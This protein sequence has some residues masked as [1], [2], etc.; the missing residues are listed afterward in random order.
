V[1]LFVS[2]SMFTATYEYSEGTEEVTSELRTL[3]HCCQHALTLPHA[4]CKT[5][6]ALSVIYYCVRYLD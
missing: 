4:F 5:A 1:E 6:C 3:T 2:V